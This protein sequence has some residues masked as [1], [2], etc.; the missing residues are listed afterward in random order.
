MS[1]ETATCAHRK[2]SLVEDAGRLASLAGG[3]NCD[4][5]SLGTMRRPPL[6][7]HSCAPRDRVGAPPS[8]MRNGHSN[9]TLG[10]I[11]SSDAETTPTADTSAH[12]DGGTK[13]GDVR[14]WVD[15]PLLRHLVVGESVWPPP[16]RSSP[17]SKPF[18]L[19]SNPLDLA[20]I[21]Q[22]DLDLCSHALS[23][24]A[25]TDLQFRGVH[26]CLEDLLARIEAPFLNKLW[27]TF[28]VDLDHNLTGRSLTQ[29]GSVR[30]AMFGKTHDSPDFFLEIRCRES[31]YQL[32]AVCSSSLLTLSTPVRLGISHPQ[33][34]W[35]DLETIQWLELLDP[36]TAVRDLHLSGEVG[37]RVG[38]AL[39]ELA[40]ERVTEVLPA[41][42]NIFLGGLQPLE[43]LPKFIERFVAARQ[44]SDHPAAVYERLREIMLDPSQD[45]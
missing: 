10:G 42:Q 11:G 24:P 43:S 5:T 29:N 9:F 7:K 8:Y 41:L 1:L 28:F 39:E 21:R 22:V 31:D 20:P 4:D 12:F 19:N 34:Q 33:S 3:D 35:R 6:G 26:E 13:Y 14:F 23:S 37:R 30:F 25:L 36:F 16:C 18:A 27:M 44:L 2:K 40:E 38:Q 32:S 17:D 45:R 15:Q